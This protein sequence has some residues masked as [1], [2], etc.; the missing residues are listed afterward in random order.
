MLFCRGG[1]LRD[2]GWSPWAKSP[3]LSAPRGNNSAES[4]RQ[5]E[6]A[7]ASRLNL[8]GLV[9]GHHGVHGVAFWDGSI[10]TSLLSFQH[11]GLLWAV[12][13]VINQGER[14]WTQ[15]TIDWLEPLS[16]KSS[17]RASGIM[18]YR[19]AYIWNNN[20][21]EPVFPEII[22]YTLHLAGMLLLSACMWL[23]KNG[24]IELDVLCFWTRSR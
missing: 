15:S 14:T 13:T 6:Q 7:P 4:W 5:M 2:T 1:E 19:K 10:H 3:L 16:T 9:G 17:Q 18:W 11:L 21:H 23:R 20:R 8:A 24:P 22:T 12:L